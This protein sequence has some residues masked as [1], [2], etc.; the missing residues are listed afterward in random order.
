MAPTIFFILIRPIMNFIRNIHF[1]LII[2]AV[3][4]LREFNFRKRNPSQFDCDVSN[5]QGERFFFKLIKDHERWKIDG[6]DLP[7][8]ISTSEETI[9]DAVMNEAVL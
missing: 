4:R 1:S 3:N 8:W 5:E 2:R 9:S 7:A 6:S